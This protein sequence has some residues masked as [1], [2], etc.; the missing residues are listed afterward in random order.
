MAEAECFIST[1]HREPSTNAIAL[2]ARLDEAGARSDNVGMRA[3]AVQHQD[4][5]QPSQPT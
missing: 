4:R 5:M 3:T 2:R 1:C